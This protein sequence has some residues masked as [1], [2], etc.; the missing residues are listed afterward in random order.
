MD[1]GNGT[2]QT[3]SL[4]RNGSYEITGPNNTQL[5]VTCDNGT[6]TFHG[7]GEQTLKG[8]SI[9]KVAQNA[10]SRSQTAGVGA[11]RTG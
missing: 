10:Q 7:L 8:W 11:G 9:N 6:V 1:P 4:D 3:F 5:Y 2:T